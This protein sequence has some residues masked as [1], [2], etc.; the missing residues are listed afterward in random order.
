MNTKHTTIFLF[1]LFTY[2]LCFGQINLL[3]SCGVNSN[4]E[5][6]QYEIQLVDS[7]LFAPRYT[8]K[9]G[10]IDPKQG[11]DFTGKKLAFFSC[12]KDGNTKGN[13]LM[14]KGEFFKL[15]KPVFNGHAGNGLIV[16]SELEKKES[17]GFDAVIIIDCPYPYVTTKEL[18]SKLTSK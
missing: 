2:Q 4:P 10:T 18:V 9:S 14:S 15:F 7:V 1:G 11:F 13:G 17:N 8:K 5:L 12:T 6:N 3:D 16:L